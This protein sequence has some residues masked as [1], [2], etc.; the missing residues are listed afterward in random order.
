MTLGWLALLPRV[1]TEGKFQAPAGPQWTQLLT[2][3]V[4]KEDSV[5]CTLHDSKIM[6]KDYFLILLPLPLLEEDWHNPL[7]AIWPIGLNQETQLIVAQW[8]SHFNLFSGWPSIIAGFG[9]STIAGIFS[10]GRVV[11]SLGRDPQ[12]PW[13]P[14]GLSFREIK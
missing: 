13:W 4:A 14:I 8:Q 10:L 11:Y 12:P 1:P 5:I 6:L 3:I 7:P 2:E 9:G